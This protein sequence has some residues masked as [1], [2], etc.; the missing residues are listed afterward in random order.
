MEKTERTEK[1]KQAIRRA[2]VRWFDQRET[3]AED[4][5]AK[6]EDTR[7]ATDTVIME[8]DDRNDAV[9][10]DN[11][12]VAVSSRRQQV[13]TVQ[14]DLTVESVLIGRHTVSSKRDPPSM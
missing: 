13:S 10:A 3:E 9:H 1:R 5:T 11:I 4:K 6:G 14:Y 7:T 8:A 12:T 2:L